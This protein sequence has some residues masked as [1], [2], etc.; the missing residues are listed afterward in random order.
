MKNIKS[1]IIGFLSATCIFLLMGV[2]DKEINEKKKW[3]KEFPENGRYLP[4]KINQNEKVVMMDSQ[5][6]DLYFPSKE[7][8]RLDM[9]K[10]K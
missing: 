3:M 9:K 4:V 10:N 2:T 7:G 5:T 1:L 8:W 6:G